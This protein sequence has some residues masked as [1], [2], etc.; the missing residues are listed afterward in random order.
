MKG[1]FMRCAQKPKW[2]LCARYGRFCLEIGGENDREV[3]YQEE[4]N[5][6]Y[7]SLAL[8]NGS[9]EP[10]ARYLGLFP[11]G[12]HDRWRHYVGGVSFYRIRQDVHFRKSRNV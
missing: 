4:P 9:G 10:Y 6:V 7:E 8:P 5:L 3:L 11:Y 2:A 12:P 1:R